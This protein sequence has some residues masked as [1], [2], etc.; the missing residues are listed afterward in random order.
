MQ[1]FFQCVHGTR[2]SFSEHL[3]REGLMSGTLVKVIETKALLVVRA[4]NAAKPKAEPQYNYGGGKRL[5]N[6]WGNQRLTTNPG[7]ALARER[8]LM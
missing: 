1:C 4:A 3:L 5:R 2:T 8:N 6:W 7:R